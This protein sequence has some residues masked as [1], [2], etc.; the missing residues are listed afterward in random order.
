MQCQALQLSIYLLK[1]ENAP[2]I[3]IHKAL[4]SR[5]YKLDY[6]QI[7]IQIIHTYRIYTKSHSAFGPIHILL[8]QTWHNIYFVD[9]RS[10]HTKVS[11]FSCVCVP[12]A[13]LYRSESATMHSHC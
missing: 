6:F 1:H 2:A 11:K 9:R 13:M 4:F 5:D 8:N 12:I 3:L 10:L 7:M